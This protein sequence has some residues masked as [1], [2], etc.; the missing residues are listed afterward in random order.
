M[1]PNF[2]NASWHGR[3][4]MNYSMPLVLLSFLS[5]G[6]FSIFASREGLIDFWQSNTRLGRDLTDPIKASLTIRTFRITGIVFVLFVA[7]ISYTM[8]HLSPKP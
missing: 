1:M 8:F 5:V 7:Y 3:A 4:W 6:L 2:F